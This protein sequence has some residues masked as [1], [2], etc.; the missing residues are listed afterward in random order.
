[1]P[2]TFRTFGELAARM[3][4]IERERE[5]ADD[6]RR[7]ANLRRTSHLRVNRPAGRGP[8]VAR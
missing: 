3:R 8:A 4:E 1:M 5:H 6:I 7:A 2:E